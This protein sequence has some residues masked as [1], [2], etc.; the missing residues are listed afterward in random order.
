MRGQG[1]AREGA[2]LVVIS[3]NFASGG[4]LPQNHFRP[5]FRHALHPGLAQGCGLFHQCFGG[6]YCAV[7]DTLGALDLSNPGFW[8]SA[9]S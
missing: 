9:Q 2:G 4:T 7:V 6:S 1:Q 8:I 5:G 3:L